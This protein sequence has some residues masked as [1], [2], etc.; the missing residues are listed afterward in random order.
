MLEIF[1]E[2]VSF[3]SFVFETDLGLI[4]LIEFFS[5]GR[6]ADVRTQWS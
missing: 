3:E 4:F 5:C 1:A 2:V 6:A